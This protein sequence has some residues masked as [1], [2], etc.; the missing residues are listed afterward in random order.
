MSEKYD[1]IIIG[2]GITGAGIARDCAMRGLKTILLE[3]NDFS[4]GTTGTCMGMLHG[5]PR[6]LLYDTKMTKISCQ[7]VSYII[8]IA[9]H[10][11][12]RIPFLRPVFK[13]D[14]FGVQ[15][16]D[17]FF[18]A[19]D[20]YHLS[21]GGKTHLVL[22]KEDALRIEPRLSQDIECAVSIDEWGVDVF[23]LVILNILSAKLHGAVVRN[24]LEVIG[25]LRDGERICGVEFLDKISG[26]TGEV[27]GE[28][29]VNASGPWTPEIAKMASVDM[30]L[31]PTKGIHIIFDRAVTSVGVVSQAV[32]GREV[33]LFP[34]E[35]SSMLG[36]TD[37]DYFG[38]P[39]EVG[40]DPNDVE[41]LLTS[42][43]RAVP[44]IREARVVRT[45]AGVRPLLYRFGE[46][47]DKLSR[48]FKIW[49]EAECVKGFMTIAG[50]KM[51]VH[52]LMAE[53]I[54]DLLCAKLGIVENCRTHEE[55][56]PG[57]ENISVE[58]IAA[59]YNLSLYATR[60]LFFR[61]GSDAGNAFSSDGKS[62]V[63]TC[64]PVL[65]SEVRYAIK[66]EYARTLDDLRRRTRLGMGPCQGNFC[67]A[68][69][70]PVL[71]EEM[72]MEAKKAHDEALNFLSER[73]KGKRLT[74]SGEQLRQEELN[75]ACY[76]CVV[77][78]RSAKEG[79]R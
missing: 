6:Y 37:D 30:R 54:T 58:E 46:T 42:V 17:A 43:E 18:R 75:Q 64:E 23:R 53:K 57:G 68:R 45:M 29:T 35:N 40:V 3:R 8:K 52:R 49:D 59:K 63:C 66:N 13:G 10:I 73:W 47:E 33:E 26:E 67:T 4:S 36:C 60:R 78:Y 70:M 71:A 72:K 14:K 1:V 19:Y 32:D 28:I 56:L 79:K 39:D 55:V 69:A 7:E 31:R 12:F 77:G 25:L 21:K 41:Y 24:H 15:A 65:E 22:S 5:G 51:V 11:V 16:V 62:C 44:S 38:D 50:G 2:G 34:H 9:P 27:R 61:H 76:G 74:L 48:D 20:K